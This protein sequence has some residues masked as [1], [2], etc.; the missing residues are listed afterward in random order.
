[1]KTTTTLSKVRAR[2]LWL[3][4][5]GLDRPNPFGRGR[6][7]VLRAIEQLGY[8]QIDTINVIERCHHHILATRVSDYRRAHLHHLQAKSK[9]VFEYWT[10]ALSY[11]P[12][13]DYRYFLG[14]M[15]RHRT[16][17]SRWFAS[18][19]AA[20]Q[21][22]VLG[23]LKAGPISIRDIE[24]DVLVEKIHPWASRKP[25]KR[26]LQLGFYTGKFV[27]SE[28]QGML[29]KYDLA[30]RH[31]DWEERPKAPSERELSC[32]LLER[33]L[34][35]Q[36][37]VSLDSICYLVPKRKKGV[38]ALI[39]AK[40]AKGELL[41]IKVDDVEKTQFWIRP[42]D[43][44]R[45]VALK[46]SLAHILSPFD[47]LAII[48]KRLH[49]LFDY[50][51]RFEAYLPPAKR[52]FGYF[53]LPTLVDDRVV[54]V[55]DLKTDR[56]EQKLLIQKWTWLPNGKSAANKKKIEDALERFEQFQLS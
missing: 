56:Q 35:A 28:R 42:E 24:D 49:A 11:I 53:G 51:H 23:L 21:R 46:H 7:G 55:L 44:E 48:R 1:M 10:H 9:D 18:V 6:E 34:R 39:A 43:L 20:D 22:K 13:R 38:A 3:E 30:D 17:P 16:T 47:P 12:T 41:P 5:Q 52:V 40:V 33:A 19:S 15:Q 27:I 31:F 14:E 37:L 45:K 4:A 36:T 50:E 25:S 54:A 32:Y 8:V 29:K 26:A 2:L